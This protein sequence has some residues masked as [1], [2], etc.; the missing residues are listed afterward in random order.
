[1]PNVPVIPEGHPD[2]VRVTDPL[3]PFNGFT[4]TVEVPVVP[5]CTVAT[6]APSVKLGGGGAVV[7]VSAITALALRAPLTPFTVSE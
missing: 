1:M 4:V 5:D 7:A 3:K 2:A 6:V